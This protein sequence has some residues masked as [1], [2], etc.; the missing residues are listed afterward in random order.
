MGKT[1]RRVV[2][3]TCDRCGHESDSYGVMYSDVRWSY[4]AMAYDG[5]WGGATHELWLCA[6]CTAALQKF[7][8]DF[9]ADTVES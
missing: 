8:F 2:T 7:V 1:E 5:A 3:Y 9:E 6:K 4:S